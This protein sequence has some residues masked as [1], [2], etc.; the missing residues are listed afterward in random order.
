M[1]KPQNGNRSPDFFL[2]A[3]V[4]QLHY[5]DNC[6]NIEIAEKLGI[7]RFRVAR[8]IERAT[9]SGIVQITINMPL[10]VD[11]DLGNALV[12]RFDLAEALV[13]PVAGDETDAPNRQAIL[14]NVGGLAARALA[15]ILHDGGK[16]GVT[17]GRTIASVAK[18]AS[19]VGGL[20]TAD[21]VQMVGG[22]SSFSDIEQTTD[23]LTQFAGAASGN[24]YPLHAPFIVSDLETA[25]RLRNESSI[26]RTLAQISHL[27][28]ALVGIGSW[29]PP[30]SQ[31]MRLFT[32]EIVQL[33]REEG[34]AADLCGIILNEAGQQLH[35]EFSEKT[36]R[37]SSTAFKKIPTVIGV[38]SGTAKAH[39]VTAALKG[40]WVDIL[41]VDSLLAK[42]ILEISEDQFSET[43]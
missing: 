28:V 39:A 15:D 11:G 42:K 7:S 35:G 6:T 23:I 16:F 38:A 2:A 33:A 22:L 1:N 19:S 34:A 21:V 17:W 40:K 25:R 30:E 24:I 43:Q 27:D 8:L 20:P 10:G 9:K 12:K 36:I 18:A 5:L 4:A 13:Y 41:I 3:R 31:M 29:D 14:D 37:A 26:N 32:P